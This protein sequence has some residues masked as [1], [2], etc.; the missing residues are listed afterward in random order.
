M[1]ASSLANII[2]LPLHTTWRKKSPNKPK[3]N[4]FQPESVVASKTQTIKLT[5]KALNVSK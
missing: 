1:T 2:V 3:H 4:S 5:L